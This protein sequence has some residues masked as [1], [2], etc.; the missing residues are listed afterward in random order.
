[1]GEACLWTGARRI[2]PSKRPAT[3][4]AE[5]GLGSLSSGLPEYFA[6]SDL[7]FAHAQLQTNW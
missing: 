6:Y 7:A 3:P 4:E 5:P 2:A 1:M